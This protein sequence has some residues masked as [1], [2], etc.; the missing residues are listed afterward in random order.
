MAKQ[1]IDIGIQGNDGTG[2][3]IRDSFRKV[4]ENFN[5]VYAIFGAGGTI[6]FTALGDTPNSYVAGQTFITG[7][8]DGRLGILAKTLTGTGS[9]TIDNSRAGELIING[10]SAELSADGFP[11]LG[12]PLDA[13]NLPIGNIPDPSPT[14]VTAFNA[15]WLAYGVSTTLD[16]L[17]INKGYADSHY[18][19][20]G[21]GNV[22]SGALRLRDEPLVAEFTDSAYDPTLT[23]NY[24]ANEALPRKA[25]VYRG[26]D[27]M[28]GKLVLSDHPSPVAG[29]GTPNGSDDLQAATKFYVD[30]KFM[31]LL[32]TC[33]FVRTVM[34]SN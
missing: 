18:V 17:P 23:S 21:V 12:G 9:V 27:T 28:T 14:L 16:K 32:Q 5:E 26:G 15:T 29:Y 30:T 7:N 24:L 10:T 19:E 4:N 2:D 11:Q 31:Y 20:K 1:E 8:A 34:T 22:V 3:S 6:D 13:N 33:T 25:V